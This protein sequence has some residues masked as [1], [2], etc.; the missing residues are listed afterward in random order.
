MTVKTPRPMRAS[1]ATASLTGD[2]IEPP[3]VDV[4]STQDVSVRRT[5][6]GMPTSEV[7]P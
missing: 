7:L 1:A 4:S 5:P 2:A 6:S 3:H